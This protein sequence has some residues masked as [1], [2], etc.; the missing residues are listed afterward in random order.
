MLKRTEKECFMKRLR[1][2]LSFHFSDAESASI[3]K[4]YEEWFENEILRGKSEK[5]VCDALKKPQKIVKNL[6]DESGSDS[7][8]VTI[9]FHNKMLQ[10]LLFM[11]IYMLAGILLL[12]ICNRNSL[13]FLY[14]AFGMNF[15]YFLIGSVLTGN[16]VLSSGRQR[17]KGNVFILGMAVLIIGFEM[18]FLRGNVLLLSGK[19]YVIGAGILSV[20]F[21]GISLYIA[22]SKMLQDRFYTFITTF[23]IS[24]VIMLLFFLIN[25]LHMLYGDVSE[26]T[27]FIYGSICIYVET[28]VL[29]ALFYGI[30]VKEQI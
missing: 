9:I 14:V 1:F 3:L 21:F 20:L 17:Y 30:H 23:Q 2:Y 27:G 24:G 28:M 25:Q 4:D 22:V 16:S 10:L 19:V 18:L 5:E 8:R 11:M 29:C 12:G 6:L 13:N 7:K 26:Y 15:L